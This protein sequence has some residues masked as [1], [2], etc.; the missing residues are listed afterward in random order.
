M[1]E[2][3]ASWRSF[4]IAERGDYIEAPLGPGVFEIRRA[5]DRTSTKLGSTRNVAQALANYVVRGKRRRLF[6][7]TREP[8][9]TGELEYRFWSVG[10]L[11]GA[12]KT[13]RDVKFERTLAT[14]QR[15]LQV[16]SRGV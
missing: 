12:K 8:Y 16:Q 5:S 2:R 9:A 3:W 11:S 4:R 1:E 15:G 10:T 14:Q 13:L 7:W 6:F